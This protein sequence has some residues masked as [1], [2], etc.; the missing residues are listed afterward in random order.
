MLAL[1]V[2][3][4]LS[5]VTR[6]NV[7]VVAI[8]FA[9][10][11]G[12]FGA[13]TGVDAVVR[14]FPSSLFLTLAGVTLL[15]TIAQENGTLEDLA[16][17]AVG[18]ARGNAR[19]LPVIFFVI[20]MLVSTVGPG[21]IASVALVVPLAMAIGARAKVPHFLT[22]LMVANGA[23]AGTLSP[24][25]SV[26]V[27]ATAIIA[28]SGD[29]GHEGKVWFANLAAHAIVALLAYF[30]FGGLRLSGEAPVACFRFGGDQVRDAQFARDRP[31]D[32]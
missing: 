4:V 32:E 8:A 7:G 13:G 1:A 25:S 5:I 16:N 24:I 31:G 29:V 28:K 9:W 22:A 2:A 19:W 10:L 18:I 23:S 11:I 21:A 30:V 12:A 20:A 15:F 26:G 27:I 17:R 14:G 6:I 3:I